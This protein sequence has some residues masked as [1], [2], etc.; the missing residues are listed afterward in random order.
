VGHAL[1]KEL[2]VSILA[3][4]MSICSQSDLSGSS[5]SEESVDKCYLQEHTP[6]EFI[7]HKPKPFRIED[8]ESKTEGGI[9][10]S[11]KPLSDEPET[12]KESSY[13]CLAHPNSSSDENIEWS[14]IFIEPDDEENVNLTIYN[15]M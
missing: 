3:D 10:D 7:N 4:D 6:R 9:E 13:D 12:K 8:A 15:G 1:L 5:S 2:R 14:D 11:C